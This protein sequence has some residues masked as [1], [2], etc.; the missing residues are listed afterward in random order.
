MWN[1]SSAHSFKNCGRNLNCLQVSASTSIKFFLTL[2]SVRAT[3]KSL[4]DASTDF[5][6]VIGTYEC[7]NVS[8]EFLQSGK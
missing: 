8:E 6:A 1:C 4:K 7:P 2:M 5:T 3:G